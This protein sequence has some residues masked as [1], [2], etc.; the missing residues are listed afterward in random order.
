MDKYL[1]N[2]FDIFK[3][4]QSMDLDIDVFKNIIELFFENIETDISLLKEFIDKKDF[5]NISKQAHKIA[6]SS[7]AV[8]FE[9]MRNIAKQIELKAKNQEKIDYLNFFEKLQK[10]LQIYKKLL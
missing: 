10:E 3:I 5:L 6:G 1:D 7:G 8:R 2:E 4:A 9:N